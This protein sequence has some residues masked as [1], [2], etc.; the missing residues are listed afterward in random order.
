V[1]LCDEHTKNAPAW[2]PGH[3]VHPPI[4]SHPA[5]RVGIRCSFP[6]IAAWLVVTYLVVVIAAPIAARPKAKNKTKAAARIFIGPRS[7][8]RGA[9]YDRQYQ[10]EMSFPSRANAAATTQYN[11]RFPKKFSCQPLMRA[12][13]PPRC[14]GLDWPCISQGF[15]CMLCKKRSGLSGPM[16]ISSKL[17]ICAL[18]KGSF[19]S[20]S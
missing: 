17:I 18:P 16:G 8:P 9:P 14:Y 19:S 11:P 6:E 4:R 10:R 5:G 1:A 15:G 13:S 12:V 7:F 3:F 20:I 2:S